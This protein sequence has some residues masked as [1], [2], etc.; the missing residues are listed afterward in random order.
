MGTFAS[1]A[2]VITIGSISKRWIVPAWRLGFQ[3]LMILMASFN[4]TRF[5]FVVA[6]DGTGNF[7]TIGEADSDTHKSRGV[8][9]ECG[10]N[11]EEEEF[12]VGAYDDE[13]VAARAYDLA[14][15]KYWGLGTLIN[16]PVR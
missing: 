1:V 6:K 8:H 10:G 5:D 9:G 12:D 14:A 2:P 7:T 4:E 13:E 3:L 16:F 15:L 11:E